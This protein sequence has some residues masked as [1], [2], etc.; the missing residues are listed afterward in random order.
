MKRANLI[1]IPALCLL[2]ACG[3]TKEDRAGSGALIGAGTGAVVGAVVGA[4][5]TGAVVGAGVGA[6]TGAMTDPDS[7][8]IGKPLWR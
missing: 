2:T 5:V 8:N 1:L 6:L 7:I 4:P 3:T